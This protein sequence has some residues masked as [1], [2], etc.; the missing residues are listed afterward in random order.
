MKK[1]ILILSFI[2]FT[3]HLFAQSGILYN[4]IKYYLGD[5]TN[6]ATQIRGIAKYDST[7]ILAING[8][9]S[10]SNHKLVIVKTNLNGDIIDSVHFASNTIAKVLY[11]GKV[12]IIDKDSN[13]VVACNNWHTNTNFWDGYIVKLNSNLDT[14]WT[15][16]YNLPDSLAGCQNANNVFTAIKET[17][18][19]GYIIT[20]K[21]YLNCNYNYDNLRSYLI[22]I[23]YNGNVLWR[24]LYSNVKQVFDVD[25][26]SDSGIVFND[27][28]TGYAINKTDK[29]GNIIWKRDPNGLIHLT[30][31]DIV[32]HNQYVISACS[33]LYNNDL[34]YPAYGIDVVKLNCNT[35]QVIWNKQYI[36]FFSF[37]C[38]GLHQSFELRILPNEDI[39]I[40]GT[41]KVT[42]HDSTNWGYKGIMLRLN[43]NGDSLWSRYYTNRAFEDECH[44]NDIALMDDGGFL[45]VGFQMP[46]DFSYKYGAWLVKTDSMGFA[47]G[48]HTMGLDK[49]LIWKNERLSIYP[50]PANHHVQI[51][52]M[53]K[54]ELSEGVLSIL[55]INGKK[56]REIEIPENQYTIQINISELEKGVYIVQLNSKKGK[57]SCK[58]VIN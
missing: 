33:Y 12:I 16:V 40:A 24:K 49:E 42:N 20:G 46:K 21:Y 58:L 26:T 10:Q 51:S 1:L 22:K 36:P 52:R 39:I 5:S 44:I 15:K 11:D 31:T 32:A 57:Q 17:L 43:S 13:I 2:A 25:I 34:A 47:P 9:D 48:A 19:G 6:S 29:N 56:I 55:D 38:F 14:I 27:T 41:S 30:N 7:L 23:D 37:E 3:I 45:F 50:N 35:G 18:D 53:N 8:N 4:K 28:Y 54:Q